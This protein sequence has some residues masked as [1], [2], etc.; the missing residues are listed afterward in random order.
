MADRY[1]VG[2]TGTWDAAATTNWSASSGG[3]SGASVP[4][5]ADNVIFDAGSDAGGIF[6]VTLSGTRLCLNITASSLDFTMTLGGTGGLTVSGNLSFPATNFTRSYT[7]TTTFNSTTSGKTITTNGVSFNGDITFNGVGGVWQLQDNFTTANNRTTTLTNGTLDIN[8]FVLSTGLFVSS[9]SN[10]RVLAFGAS[11]SV[12]ITITTNNVSL[13]D[14]ATATNLS[15]TGT[16]AFRVTTSGSNNRAFK[17]GNTAAGY[18]TES[19]ALNLYTGTAIVASSVVVPSS[20]SDTYEIDGRYNNIDFTYSGSGTGL[21]LSSNS[22][23]TI[24][25]NFKL[26]SGMSE[27]GNGLPYT[28]ASTST[29]KTINFNGVSTAG[30]ITLNGVGGGWTLAAALNMTDNSGTLTLT[31]GSFD[32]SIYN[33]TTARFS[34]AAGTTLSMGSGTWTLT[35]TGAVWTATAGATLNTN[36]ANIVLSNTTTTAR[37]F[38]GGGYTYN[39]L[40]IGG[41]TGISTLTFTGSNT[42][43]EIASTKTVAHTMLFTAGTTTTVAAWTAKGTVGN[44]LT[45]GSVTAAQHTLVK[46]GGGVVSVDYASISY[47]NASPTSTWYAPNSTDGGNNTGWIFASVPVSMF[48]MF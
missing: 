18:F 1:W 40:T 29:G 14:F 33:V 24:Y 16:P 32:A 5:A 15:I 25:G 3:A 30:T 35:G 7:G 20:G 10:T 38:A 17:F 34:S 13:I 37:T 2:G 48:L 41:T 43:S 26:A 22:A 28:F 21:N 11:G 9:N 46:T 45:I 6:T 19:T 44:V 27:N 23:P 31:N 36:T 42:F 39:K 47:S 4:T 8:N 12:S